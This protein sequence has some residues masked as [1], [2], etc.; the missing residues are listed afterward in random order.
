MLSEEIVKFRNFIKFKW[1]LDNL[2]ISQ[3]LN[4]YYDKP[5]EELERVYNNFFWIWKWMI[6]SKDKI[7]K[8]SDD[9]SQYWNN[10]RNWEKEIWVHFM[11]AKVKEY[12]HSFVKVDDNNYECIYS[13]IPA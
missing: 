4:I 5:I 2:D 3:L 9:V 6:V 7:L 13:N 8:I 1:S 12:C 11:I 10:L